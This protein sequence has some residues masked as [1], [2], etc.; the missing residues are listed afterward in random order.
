[1]LWLD[2]VRDDDELLKG[3]A[4]VTMDDTRKA[5]DRMLCGDM[6]LSVVSRNPDPELERIIEQWNC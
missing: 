5:I 1:M 4:D 2:R 6:K 3:L